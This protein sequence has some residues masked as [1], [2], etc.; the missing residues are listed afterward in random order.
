ML[1]HPA[2]QQVLAMKPHKTYCALTPMPGRCIDEF[3]PYIWP[4]MGCGSPRSCHPIPS[5]SSSLLKRPTVPTAKRSWRRLE[6]QLCR[7]D[8]YT[9][10]KTTNEESGIRGAAVYRCQCKENTKRSEC[11]LRTPVVKRARKSRLCLT[12]FS[13]ATQSRSSDAS[14]PEATGIHVRCTREHQERRA[15]LTPQSSCLS[16]IV[17]EQAVGCCN[18][19]KNETQISLHNYVGL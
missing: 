16:A 14:R 13:Y 6:N 11:L 2:E 7:G 5:M 4:R 3:Q 12:T 9:Q 17:Y 10:G 1:G 8:L 18:P 19:T 15:G